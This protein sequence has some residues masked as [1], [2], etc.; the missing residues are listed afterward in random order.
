MPETVI[1]ESSL[2]AAL[3][4]RLSRLSPERRALLAARLRRRIRTKPASDGAVLETSQ[5]AALRQ[6]LR[7]LSPEKRA[8]LVARLRRHDDTM[9]R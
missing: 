3:H 7:H 6:Q 4:Q 5:D 1:L 8:L 9:T 2:D